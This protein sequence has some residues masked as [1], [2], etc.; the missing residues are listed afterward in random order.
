[1]SV[2]IM[3]LTVATLGVK[4]FIFGVVAENKKVSLCS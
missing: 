2:K 3:S 4:S 1:M